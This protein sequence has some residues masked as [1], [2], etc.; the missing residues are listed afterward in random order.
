MVSRKS[1]QGTGN[2]IGKDGDR[3]TRSSIWL[4]CETRSKELLLGYTRHFMLGVSLFLY[5]YLPPQSSRGETQVM[6]FPIVKPSICRTNSISTSFLPTLH[7]CLF[8]IK[9]ALF[10]LLRA[11]F[12]HLVGFLTVKS[13]FP[14]VLFTSRVLCNFLAY[15]VYLWIHSHLFP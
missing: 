8:L 7:L 3:R 11:A 14:L 13:N 5:F 10:C 2:S 6:I 12:S 15:Y 1:I 4:W 9:A